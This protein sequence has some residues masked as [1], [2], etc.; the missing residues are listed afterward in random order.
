MQ[1]GSAGGDA[2]RGG[3]QGGG[4]E[5]GRVRCSLVL[6]AVDLCFQ[7][8]QLQDVPWLPTNCKGQGTFPTAAPTAIL[9]THSPP[10]VRHHNEIHGF[11]KHLTVVTK[12]HWPYLFLLHEVLDGVLLVLPLQRGEEAKRGREG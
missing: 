4:C 7:V 11:A 8:V 6:P 5:R 1:A 9:P 12:M 10:P 3:E 2:F